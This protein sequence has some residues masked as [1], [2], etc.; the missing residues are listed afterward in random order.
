M[1]YPIIV[2]LYGAETGLRYKSYGRD[3]RRAVPV[4]LTLLAHVLVALVYIKWRHALATSA[5]MDRDLLRLNAATLMASLAVMA[6]YRRF[7]DYY[8]KKLRDPSS[9]FSRLPF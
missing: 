5:E 4:G 9:F 2:I 1:G 8:K 7:N 6:G 3:A